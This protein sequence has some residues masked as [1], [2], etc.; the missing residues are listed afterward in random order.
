M[1][2]KKKLM[3]DMDDVICTG[4]FL[5][6]INE[7]MGS[8]YTFDDFKEFRM[9]DI[10]PDKDKFFEWF[11]TKNVYDYCELN[12]GCYQVLEE[13]NKEYELYIATD[14]VWPEIST[15]CGYILEQKFNFLQEKLPFI[16]SRQYIFLVNKNVLDM[17]I[18]LDDKISNLDGSETK[19]LFSAYH[20]FGYSDDYLQSMGIERV[21]SWFDVRDKLLR[22]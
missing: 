18:R 7:Y 12:A 3:V 20:N 19:L 1:S 2:T 13:L 4:G 10:I 21:D 5:Y 9:Q 14:Y 8:N 22:K 11:M 15:K 16:N 17:D 6:L